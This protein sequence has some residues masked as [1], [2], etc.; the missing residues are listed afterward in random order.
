MPVAA[1]ER[2]KEAAKKTVTRKPHKKEVVPNF[3]LQSL[4]DQSVTY[5]VVVEKVQ[6]EI[7]VTEVASIDIYVKTEKGKAY[8][9]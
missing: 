3:V 2:A 8:Y 7:K 4:T 9:D 1:A 5:E 6:A